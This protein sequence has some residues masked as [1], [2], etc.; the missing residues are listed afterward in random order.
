MSVSFILGVNGNGGIAEHGLGSCGSDDHIFIAVLYGITEVPEGAVLF[1]IFY[2]CVGKSRC[3]L[4]AE[5][6]D[7]E[8][9]VDQAL[10]IEVNEILANSLGERFVHGEAFTGP[11]AGGAE[12]L[13]LLNNAVTVFML[14]IPYELGELFT[15]EIVTGKSLLLAEI[16][17]Y[18]DLGCDT[19]VVGSGHP[20]RAI[21][22]HA[23]EADDG[24]LQSF[25]ESVSHVKLTRNVRRRNHDGERL[26]VFVNFRSEI[27]CVTPL[28]VEGLFDFTR[29]V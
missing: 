16:F 18:L 21:T 13:E 28:A 19:C 2:F 9:A 4:R 22:A 10:I 25:I 12:R 17:F 6:A 24:I 14:P 1:L 8:S 5:V 29:I 27:A 26:F 23:L 11:V 20:E 15:A 3:A 7:T